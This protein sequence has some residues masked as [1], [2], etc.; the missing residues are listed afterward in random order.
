MLPLHF[1]KCIDLRRRMGWT[2]LLAESV[3]LPQEGLWQSEIVSF[4]LERNFKR[5][6]YDV[7]T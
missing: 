3:A 7:V 1:M 2:L 4:K 5:K 6:V